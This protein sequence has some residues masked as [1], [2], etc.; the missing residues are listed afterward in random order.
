VIGDEGKAPLCGGGRAEDNH[1][2]GVLVEVYTE[3]RQPA[4][5]DPPRGVSYEKPIGAA[6]RAVT[7]LE[8][9]ERLVGGPL[10]R[11]G[12]TFTT[13]CPLPDHDDG[14]PSF[15]VYADNERGWCCFGCGRGGDVV[16]LYALAWGCTDMRVAAAELLMEFGH[17]V[18]PRPPSWFHR[19]E[20]QA[21]VRERIE[22][23]RIEHVAMLVFRLIWMPWLKRLPED[24]REEATE[25]AWRDALWMAD[26][27]YASR[28]SA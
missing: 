10:S 6:K 1:P 18:P 17:E 2:K 12:Q 25:G 3:A 11:R 20:R 4:S 5:T 27:L 23:G 24:V 14:S 26:R 16:H 8:L 15:T 19:Q 22:R 7:V 21:P 13:R 9:A 28:R